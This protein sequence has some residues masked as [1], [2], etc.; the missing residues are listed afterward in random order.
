MTNNWHIVR[1]WERALH[2]VV[3]W[4]GCVWYFS[5]VA[6]ADGTSCRWGVGGDTPYAGPSDIARIPI[7]RITLNTRVIIANISIRF[8]EMITRVSLDLVVR[9]LRMSL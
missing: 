3:S 9:W 7:C 6:W 8:A 2:A 4:L 1:T 5:L